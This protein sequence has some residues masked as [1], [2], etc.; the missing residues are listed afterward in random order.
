M[1][2]LGQIRNETQNCTRCN[3]REKC[4]S[5]LGIEAYGQDPFV[6]FIFGS[7]VSKESDGFQTVLDVTNFN[8][9][10]NIQKKLQ[11]GIAITYETKCYSTKS[12][13]ASQKT[14]CSGYFIQKEIQAVS[15]KLI[16]G[17]G[18]KENKLFSCDIYCDAY[19]R[20]FN[21]AKKT[22]DLIKKIKERLP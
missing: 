14:R 15:A 7:K 3:L 20:V 11:V 18:V 17:F 1:L 21:N 8:I 22:K 13:S 4:L 2:T 5:P 10:E 12:Y 16:V 9:L 6:L 19:A